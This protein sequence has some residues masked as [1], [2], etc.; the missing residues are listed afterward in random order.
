MSTVPFAGHSSQQHVSGRAETFSRDAS[1]CSGDPGWW[2][3]WESWDGVEVFVWCGYG[4]VWYGPLGIVSHVDGDMRH[5]RMWDMGYGI[6]D[7]EG[8]RVA[9]G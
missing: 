8:G 7:M 9:T 1:W 2:V 3:W 4:M 6:W 5:C